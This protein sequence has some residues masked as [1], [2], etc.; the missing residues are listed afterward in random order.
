MEAKYTPCNL[1]DLQRHSNHFNTT[2]L[3]DTRRFALPSSKSTTRA[4]LRMTDS[5]YRNEM[6]KTLFVQKCFTADLMTFL[7]DLLTP[8]YFIHFKD[9][10]IFSEVCNV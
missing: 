7:R 1:T 9:R 2:L 5:Q 8:R 3:K 10:R 6:I 4:T